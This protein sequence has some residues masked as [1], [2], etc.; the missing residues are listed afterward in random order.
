MGMNSAEDNGVGRGI[1]GI[2]SEVSMVG[3]SYYGRICMPA[4]AVRASGA[5][6]NDRVKMA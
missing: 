1:H 5:G 6:Q 2:K 4:I 3:A